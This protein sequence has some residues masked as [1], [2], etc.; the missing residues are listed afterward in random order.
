MDVVVR[1]QPTAQSPASIAELV[2]K[3]H[4]GA[5]ASPGPD[6]TWTLRGV[7]GAVLAQL[8]ERADVMWVER[9]GAHAITR[10]EQFAFDARRERLHPRM[11]R[12][13]L[14]RDTALTVR[15]A[16]DT[17]LPQLV[18]ATGVNLAL[19]RVR[20]TAVSVMLP[21]DSGAALTE[22][23]ESL[24]GVPGVTSV[25]RVRLARPLHHDGT[26]PL[27]RPND[28]LYSIQWPLHHPDA[29]INV[30]AAWALAGT[31]PVTVAVIDTGSTAHPDLDLKW[32]PG[33]DFISERY[34]SVDGDGRDGDANDDGDY[35]DFGECS[36]FFDGSSWHGTHVA[37]IIGAQANNNEGIAGVAP[38]ARL[39]HIRA[40]GRC[41]GLTED[42]ADAIK[43][44]AGVPVEGAPVNRNPARVINMSL[45]GPG[46]C[47]K[48]E[49][50]AVDAA[51]AR[52]AIVVVA[53]G[54]SADDA[55][56]FS[57]ANCKGVIAVAASN[58]D[59]VSSS[60]SNFGEIV[61]IS[62]PGGDYDG[63]QQVTSTLNS[64]AAG[65]SGAYYQPY[66]GTSM[67]A[68]HVAGV[69]A[70]MLSRDPSLTAGQ[71]L[72]R[73]QQTARKINGVL[74]GILDAGAAVA[75]VADRRTPQQI[76]P[77]SGRMRLTELWDTQTNRFFTTGD[78]V[79]FNA[80]TSG[81]LGG[82][83]VATDFVADAFD[84]AADAPVFLVPQ[85]VCRY[86]SVF[87]DAV[88]L[89]VDREQCE[90]MRRS[91]AWS[92]DGWA[93]QALLPNGNACP[94]GT[95]P[96]HELSAEGRYRYVGNAAE[97]GVS[98]VA[99]WNDNGVAY[100]LPAF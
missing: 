60:Y 74:G 69:V 2:A 47:T 41:G 88:R 8:R 73:L 89:A 63:Y 32:V 13:N 53:A 16:T 38:N 77:A 57:P 29:G 45:G 43:W 75:A 78:L 33:Y 59:S 10:E 35:S 17:V 100:C 84:F 80:L 26:P 7:P 94:S 62:A 68:P 64:G 28:P 15:A 40:L 20:G 66:A 76:A 58:R 25:E 44:A 52:G 95:I 6:G 72:N 19:A 34:I 27:K 61:K 71:V 91:S 5:S 70:L 31:S 4:A 67:A 81:A 11:L 93:F 36:F 21:K 83:W 55:K 65:Q 99:G 98:V 96:V 42:V 3:G 14:A 30:E 82:R 50:D 79:E 49:Q 51:L 86:R 23:A 56:F 48:E 22:A 85:P 39:Q 9:A 18:A 92:N 97:R 12:V 37:G 54:N 90:H 24:A 87:N 1:F 46:P